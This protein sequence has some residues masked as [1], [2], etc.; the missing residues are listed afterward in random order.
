LFHRERV[1]HFHATIA[2]T[3]LYDGC[4]G[5]CKLRGLRLGVL[6]AQTPVTVPD[7]S[8]RGFKSSF[9]V[10]NMSRYRAIRA[11]ASGSYVG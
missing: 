10:K 5:N 11:R 2:S 3:S 1:L 8:I 6:R 7:L 9:S 4:I